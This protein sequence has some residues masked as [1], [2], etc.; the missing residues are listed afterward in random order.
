MMQNV[1]KQEKVVGSTS[2]SMYVVL[3]LLTY[4]SNATMN[5]TV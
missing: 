1:S 4:I 3:R 2:Y 5:T